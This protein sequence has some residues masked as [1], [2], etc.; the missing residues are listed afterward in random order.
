MFSCPIRRNLL[1]RLEFM[2]SSRPPARSAVESCKARANRRS[3]T[4]STLGVSSAYSPL[5]VVF[6]E[7]P[8]TLALVIG[9]SSCVDSEEPPEYEH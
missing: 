3:T 9:V 6:Q 8:P 4:K 5:A 7:A 2:S 1:R